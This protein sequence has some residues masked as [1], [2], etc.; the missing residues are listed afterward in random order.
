M[1]VGYVVN[2]ELETD[3]KENFLYKCL[4]PVGAITQETL[5]F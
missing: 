1:W 2:E 5:I 4:L 3:K